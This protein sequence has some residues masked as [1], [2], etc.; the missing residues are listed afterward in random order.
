MILLFSYL[1]WGYDPNLP[2]PHRG[3]LQPLQKSPKAVSLSKEQQTRLQNNHPVFL[4]VK[5]EDGQSAR[6]VAVQ[7]IHANVDRVWDTILNYPRYTDWVDNV[8]VCSVYKKNTNI[9][10]TELISEVMYISFGVYTQNHIF[11]DQ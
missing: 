1:L 7:Y 2:H 9:W 11:R 4:R 3:K 8:T 6:G 5:K 10:Y